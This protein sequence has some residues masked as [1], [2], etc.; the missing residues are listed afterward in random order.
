MLT[1]WWQ[2]IHVHVSDQTIRNSFDDGG[3]RPQDTLVGP[4]LATQRHATGI[5]QR[6][7]EMATEIANILNFATVS[8]ESFK[9]VTREPSHVWFWQVGQKHAHEQ[10]SAERYFVEPWQCS[11]CSSLHKGTDTSTAKVAALQWSCPVHLVC[12]DIAFML[13]TML[14]D[15]ADLQHV[16]ICHSVWAGLLSLMSNI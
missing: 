11:S 9:P 4:V 3:S 14:E 2:S 5:H 1:Q 13:E 15:M 7:P 12:L 10:Y 16:R 6:T 8:L